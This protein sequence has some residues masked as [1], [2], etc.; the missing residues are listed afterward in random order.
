MPCRTFVPSGYWKSTFSKRTSP[1][2][3]VASI[4]SGASIVSGGVSEHRLTR[5]A[6]ATA[7][8]SRPVVCAISGQRS[9]TG[10]EIGDHHHQLAQTHAAL[11]HVRADHTTTSAVPES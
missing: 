4:A 2:I 7:P 6:P 10:A 1:V 3:V 11:Q 8:C 9:V 5:F